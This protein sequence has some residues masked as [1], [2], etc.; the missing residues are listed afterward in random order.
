MLIVSQFILE[1]TE[2]GRVR[3]PVGVILLNVCAFRLCYAS[4]R[5]QSEAYQNI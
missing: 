1:Y 3:F 5:A 4:V 2:R